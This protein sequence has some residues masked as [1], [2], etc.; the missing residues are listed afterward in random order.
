M[1]A[2]VVEDKF[3]RFVDDF[4]KFLAIRYALQSDCKIKVVLGNGDNWSA[5]IPLRLRQ[6]TENN[7]QFQHPCIIL[8]RSGSA[9]LSTED[10]KLGLTVA[11]FSKEQA[12][13]YSNFDALI[14]LNLNEP[15]RMKN[16]SPYLWNILLAHQ[17]LHLVEILSGLKLIDEPA[18]RHD[19]EEHE[20]LEHLHRFVCWI[21]GI[22]EA[23]DRYIPYKK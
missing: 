4:Y 22:D 16:G 2:M 19:Y 11:G 18:T 10:K 6:A 15:I 7:L 3:D 21:G 13:A 9:A 20:A 8:D 1:K 17:V 14:F 5:L 23:I 12:E